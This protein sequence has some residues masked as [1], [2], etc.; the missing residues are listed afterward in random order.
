MLQGSGLRISSME[1]GAL[2]AGQVGSGALKCE[3]MMEA[4][5]RWWCCGG[6]LRCNGRVAAR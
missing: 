3:S 1:R 2:D 6:A 4:G 5:V